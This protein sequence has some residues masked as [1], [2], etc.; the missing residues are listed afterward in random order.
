MA[1][2][3]LRRR[4]V[5][6]AWTTGLTLT[7]FALFA[8]I[9]V[10]ASS[11]NLPGSTFEGNDG[12][13]VVDTA[14]NTDW[15]NAPNRHIGTDL[16]TG[17]GDNSFGQGAKED[18]VSTTVV[19]GSIPNSKADLAQ[20]Y[21][22]NEQVGNNIFLYL[23]WTRSN[24][25][26]TTNFDFEL[27]QKAQPDLTT[28]GPKTLVRTSGDLLINY[29]FQGQGTPQ[30][31]I[32][33][34]NG[35]AWSAPTDASAYSEA[36]IN[37]VQVNN[38]LPG[39]T[40]S[41][42][43]PLQFGEAA[44]NLTA[45]GIFPSGVCKAFGSVYVKSRSSTAFNSEI[46]DFIAPVS[47]SIANCASIEV[48]KV[49]IPS[50]D[51]TDTSFSFTASYDSDGFSLKNGG[52]NPSGDL[53]PGTYSVSETVPA[54][55]TLTAA[56]CD[57]GS[58]PAAID[59]GPAEHV[60]CT[61]TN[62]LQQGAIKVHKASIKG[63]ALA[64]AHFSI[65]GQDVISD[66]NG[67]ACV[68]HLN[69]GSYSV[70]ET[71]PPPGYAI[72][73]NSV[74]TVQVNSA[75]TCASAVAPLDLQFN[76]TPL[77]DVLVKADSQVAGGTQS[78]ITCVDENNAGIGDSPSGNVEHAQVSAPGLSPGTYTCTIVVDP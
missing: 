66:A 29:L 49:T 76:D 44:L 33:T 58:D 12:N 7:A 78:Q 36:A 8:V 21:V 55:W 74:H 31:A 35:T 9:F 63:Q 56:T 43:P 47:V 25:S 61:F 37:L 22:G 23:G 17:A 41:P 50:P 57:D 40:P 1:V 20:F 62:T 4:R 28:P 10:A 5:R 48:R 67:D 16:P 3:K 34:W 71:A 77:T 14:G 69:F 52:S 46:K 24:T 65:A 73:D 15:I 2:L 59:L 51:P 45:A 30:I 32:R 19:S 53:N 11:A 39:G 38:P 60:I 72:D 70:Q 64:G 13:L 42:I 75:Q 27:N 54:N 6:R 26:G 18:L 68:D